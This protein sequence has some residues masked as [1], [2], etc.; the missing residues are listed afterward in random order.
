M[1]H[2]EGELRGQDGL[3]LYY[4][5][6]HPRG[7][8]KAVLGMVHGL[9]SHSG[10]FRS[11][12]EELVAHGYS[13]YGLDLRGHGKSLGQRGYIN[14]WQEFRSDINSFWQLMVR[15]NQ[16]KPCFLLGHSLGA[17]IV[18]DYALFSSSNL[19]GIITMAP[20]IGA[21]G[22]SPF[23]LA[24]SKI[25]SRIW[26]QFTMKTGISE[27]YA[28]RN[29]EFLSAYTSDPL[30]HHQGTVRLATE[31]LQTNKSIQVNICS[32]QSPIL[33]LQGG[34]RF[35]DFPSKQSFIF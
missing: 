18:L 4:Q 10:W 31:F 9:G 14:N 12:S 15:Q 27:N 8:V 30:R 33:I 28:S 6:W 32:L 35:G 34:R 11:L 7:K 24:I 19:H 3:K 16:T 2:F 25:L 5:S 21:V 23:K 29:L 17:V 13:L 20:A 1:L 26:P 22:V